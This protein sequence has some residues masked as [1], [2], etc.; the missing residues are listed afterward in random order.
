M[1]ELE[2]ASGGEVCY[3]TYEWLVDDLAEEFE[4]E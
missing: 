3:E 1:V 2:N 4:D